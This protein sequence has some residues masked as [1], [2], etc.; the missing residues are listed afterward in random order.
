M[1]NAVKIFR[2]RRVPVFES[3]ELEY[4]RSVATPNLLFRFSRPNCVVLPE[5]A[6]H[7]QAI[8]RQARKQNLEI[9]IKC[10]GH[11]YAGHSTASGGISLD[12]RRMNT[13]ELDIES[14][15][16]TMDSG[17]QWGHV[18]KT[19]VNGHHDGLMINGGRCPFVGVS[20]FILGGGLGPFTR[21]FG[22]GSD[23]LKEATIVTAD[24]M[25]VTVNESNPPGSREARLFWALRGAGSG[26][27]GVVVEM[28]L[29]VHKLQ[30]KNVVAGRYQWFPNPKATDDFITTMNN[31][32]TTDWPEQM[33]IDS[34]WMCDPRVTSGNGVRFLVYY[35]GKKD[36]FDRLIDKH[37]KQ[38]ELANQ[39]K[40]RSLLE[41]STRF[42]H[43][44]LVSQW[45]EETTRAF[46]SN[47]TY[48]VYSSFVFDNNEIR[49]NG[50][51][52]IIRKEMEAFR[53]LYLKD[54]VQ[55]L[56]TWIHSGGKAREKKPED[57]AFFWREAVYHTYVTVEWE[58]KWMEKDMRGFLRRVK[59]KLRLFSLKREAAYI[60]YPD[61]A[62]SK[63]VHERAYFGDNLAELRRIKE[64]WDKD[65]FFKSTQG[66]KL[67]PGPSG[68]GKSGVVV[69]TP[70][71]VVDTSDVVVDTSDEEVTTDTIARKQW[72]FFE[73]KDFAKEMANL[74]FS[75]Q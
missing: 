50:V 12:L 49:I 44:T 13:V 10:N 33:T 66:V 3:G 61:G 28:K 45:S 54:N 42:L 26:N 7:V 18:Y 17:C 43:E 14:E 68:G 63:K 58:D 34:T 59:K 15:T 53:K 24:G 4:E 21:S 36:E 56:V 20:G 19:L 47:K 35:D 48:S 57:T 65:N 62:L 6:S 16:V 73:V 32:Y 37:I 64:I 75:E 2:S 1:D 67:P 38:P 25:L 5:S 72:E 8:V 70:D 46:P 52:D 40:R 11:S 71:V 41:K 29:K 22:M 60:N 30:N 9:T 55:F 23:A 31:F 39:L 27:F 69:D 51:T 74:G